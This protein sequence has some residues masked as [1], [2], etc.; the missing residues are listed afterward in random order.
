MEFKPR[1]PR[2]DV[3]V[4]PTHP[5]REAATLVVGVAAIIVLG[6]QAEFG[7]VGKGADFL[8]RL[9]TD[10]RLVGYVSTHPAS[11]ERTE[12]LREFAREQGWP[13]SGPS[14]PIKGGQ[15]CVTLPP[16]T[17]RRRE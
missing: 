11:G 13:L 7:H 4:S 10:S 14:V 9:D 16:G 12:E 8:R 1:I 6:M 17:D 5:L 15:E 3:N 2:E